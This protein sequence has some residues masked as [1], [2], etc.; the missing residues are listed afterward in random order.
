MKPQTKKLIIIGVVLL[1][2]LWGWK[3]LMKLND[4]N[5]S[6]EDKVDNPAFRRTTE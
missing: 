2:V 5:D 6:D 3:K 1:V 4:I